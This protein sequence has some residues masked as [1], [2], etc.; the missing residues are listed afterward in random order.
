MSGFT[1]TGVSCDLTHTSS[2]KVTPRSEHS[3]PT[4]LPPTETLVTQHTV[5]LF[6]PL[7]TKPQKDV[8]KPTYS[9]L[10]K[11]Q[12]VKATYL[13]GEVSG[14]TSGAERFSSTVLGWLNVNQQ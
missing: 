11:D 5:L 12:S 3:L 6:N 7:Y 1:F 10:K 14:L 13:A 4:V 9:M 2:V 8:Q